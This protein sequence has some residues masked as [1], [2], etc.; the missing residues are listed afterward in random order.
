MR[1][2]YESTQ[3]KKVIEIFNPKD[4]G[5]DHL[6]SQLVFNINVAVFETLVYAD[7]KKI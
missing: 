4:K 3:V 1:R 5:Q 7:S 6:V 2:K